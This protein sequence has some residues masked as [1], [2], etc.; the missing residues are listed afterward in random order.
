M[1]IVYLLTNLSNNKKYIGQKSECRIEKIDGIDTIIN[2]KSE[3]PYYGSS[4]NEEM[5]KDLCLHKFSASIIEI[6]NNKKELLKREDYYVRLYNAVESDEYYNL[7][8][9]ADFSKYRKE[10]DKK[11]EKRDFQNSIKNIFGETYKEYASRE[12]N[13]SKRVNSARR[14]LGFENL[15]D[16]YLDIYHK[17]NKQ[18]V[19]NYAALAREYSVERHTIARLVQDVNLNKFYN[20]VKNRTSKMEAKIKDFRIKG[21][22]IKKIAEMLNLEFITV[23]Y[24][25]GTKKIKVKNFVVAERKGLTEDELGYKIMEKFLA[26][27]GFKKITSDLEMTKLQA[28]RYFHRFIRK[29]LEINDFKGIIK[30]ETNK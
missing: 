3:L 9:P 8:Y 7:G 29:H 25:I 26:G 1:N 24:Y 17:I 15:E 6:V 19:L 23:L 30:E 13:I 22:S 21:A 27:E 18:E 4:K 28:T 12:S 20:E 2:L 11:I 14:K 10:E 5:K 16:F